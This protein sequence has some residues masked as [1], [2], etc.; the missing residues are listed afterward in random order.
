MAKVWKWSVVIFLLTGLLLG[1]EGDM[2]TAMMETPYLVFDLVTTVILSACF[3][4]GFLKII[5][6]T[7]FMNYLSFLLKPLLRLIY[8]PIL[9]EEHVYSYLSSNVV[10][11]L[12]GLGSLATLSGIKAFQ[13][14]HELN[15][16]DNRPS[17]EML[18][19]VIVNTAGLCLFPS[20]LIML[21][22]Q[23]GSNDLYAFYPYMLIIAI[24]II[25]VGLIVQRVIDHE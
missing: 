12:L 25:V 20:S 23:I 17:R 15:P 8:G 3:W 6:K 4:G 18:T 5:E 19:L 9:D 13:R 2:M 21:R 11:N 22:Q 24:T 1:R 7:G 10:A 14:L 16:Y